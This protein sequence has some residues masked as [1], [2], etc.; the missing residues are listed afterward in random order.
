VKLSIRHWSKTEKVGAAIGLGLVGF[1]A[2]ELIKNKSALAE[3]NRLNLPNPLSKGDG[4]PPSAPSAA[5]VAIPPA[6]QAAA[7]QAQAAAETGNF[8]PPP[9]PPNTV[10]LPPPANQPTTSGGSTTFTVTTKGDASD[11]LSRLKVRAGPGTSYPMISWLMKGSSV[12]SN[13]VQS[14]NASDGYTWTQV[15]DPTVPGQLLGWA[16][17]AFLTPG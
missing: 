8:P 6:T 5:P 16:A 7:A 11:P 15:Y 1:V 14:K 12:T 13:G 3:T 2:Y 10:I 17:T 9:L 4:L